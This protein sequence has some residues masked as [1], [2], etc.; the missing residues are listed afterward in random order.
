MT[1][2]QASKYLARPFG[3]HER[4]RAVLELIEDGIVKPADVWRV[5]Q[6]EWPSFDRIPHYEYQKLFRN[7]RSSWSPLRRDGARRRH[8]VMLDSTAPYAAAES[9]RANFPQGLQEFRNTPRFNVTA[10]S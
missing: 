4:P 1:P 9:V 2:N 5:L 7:I 10:A 6:L 8:R 3:S